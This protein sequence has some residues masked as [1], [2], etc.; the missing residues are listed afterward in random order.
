MRVFMS[1][2][3]SPDLQSDSPSGPFRGRGVTAEPREER[4][5]RLLNKPFKVCNTE[6]AG[7]ESD[8]YKK[9]V[10]CSA[11]LYVPTTGLDCVSAGFTPKRTGENL[12]HCETGAWRLSELKDSGNIHRNF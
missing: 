4:V 12:Q 6:V 10:R 5:Q 1:S 3:A 8:L 9:R 11:I 2:V 7:N